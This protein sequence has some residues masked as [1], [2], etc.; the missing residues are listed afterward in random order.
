MSEQLLPDARHSEL[1]KAAE[2]TIGLM[3]LPGID[4]NSA[5][6]KVAADHAMN[7]NEVELV[8]HAVN[9]SS[10]LAHLQDSRPEDR[11]KPFPLIDAE[12]VKSTLAQQPPTNA[13]Q[14][15]GSRYG[16]QEQRSDTAELGAE[17]GRDAIQIKDQLDKKSSYIPRRT[18]PDYE[19][20]LREGWG[21]SR[22]KVAAAQIPSQPDPN[23]RDRA[24]TKLNHAIEECRTQ[25][26]GARD[27][28]ARALDAIAIE[29][30]KFDA[31]RWSSVEKIAWVQ[32]VEPAF[33][34]LCYNRV[35]P[36]RWG[37][38]ERADLTKVAHPRRLYASDREQA[39]AA[40]IVDACRLFKESAD[41]MAAMRLLQEK[42][43][44]LS[45][46]PTAMNQVGEATQLPGQSMTGQPVAGDLQDMPSIL[47]DAGATQLAG[48]ENPEL[49]ELAPAGT[50]IGAMFSANVDPGSIGRALHDA[51]A[52]FFAS[53]DV[54]QQALGE[55]GE[56]GDIQTIIGQDARQG[57]RNV[58]ARN[59]LQELMQDDVIG[60]Y[61]IPDVV[62]AY[63]HALS[64]NP[65]FGHAE[66][67]SYIRHHLATQG[68]VGLDLQIRARPKTTAARP[69]EEGNL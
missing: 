54:M 10:Q 50:K 57:V 36:E 17:K 22:E 34:D 13:D 52:E 49:E 27:K 28:C 51:P 37:P 31:P 40:Q 64:V 56:P 65:Q 47:S 44:Q 53:P 35:E 43:A 46:A 55:G 60:S 21:L 18:E 24:L 20:I 4:P 48:E 1:L 30:R 6:A 58:Q 26:Y 42:L 15:T 62:E 61:S 33:L 39:L 38:G 19:K 29:M 25:A 8:A 7:D 45:P 67:V 14:F 16:T 9:N 3:N 32:G 5:L 68:A 12:R 66:L 69:T 2:E 59:Q 11:E 41:C 63:N 23:L